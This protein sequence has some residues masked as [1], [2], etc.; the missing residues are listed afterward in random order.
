MLFVD[1]N[2][3]IIYMI[4]K[5]LTGKDI[6]A[7]SVT[8]KN[9][10]ND[11]KLFYPMKLLQLYNL[12]YQNFVNKD[13]IL[14]DLPNE[15]FIYIEEETRF[16]EEKYTKYKTYYEL[17]K[18]NFSIFIKIYEKILLEKLNISYNDY[19]SLYYK[20]TERKDKIVSEYADYLHYF[21]YTYYDYI[22]I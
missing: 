13:T 12:E 19:I 18:E 14:C 20:I 6:Y 16:F 17:N 2:Q 15:L 3:D 10:R 11:I 9:I 7:I 21:G 4:S 5:F 8:C 22:K 1:L